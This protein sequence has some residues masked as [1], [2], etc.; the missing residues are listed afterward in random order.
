MLVEVGKRLSA[1][2]RPA[3]TVSRFGGDEFTI[4]CEN[5]DQRAA[6][7]VAERILDALAAPVVIDRNELFANASIGIAVRADPR[8]KAEEMLRDADAAMYRAKEQ[9]RSRFALFDGDLRLQATERLAIE[10]D[11]RRALERD[12]L[13][14]LYQPDIE[15]ASGRVHGVEALVRWR[16][17]QRGLLS[18]H[19][20][21]PIAE[22]SGLIVGLG[23]WVVTEACR[24]LR[25]WRDEGYSLCVSVN[26]SPRQL[27]DPNLPD[28][29]GAAL[30]ASGADPA[31]L[32]LEITESAAVEASSLTLGALRDLGVRLAL[33]DFGAGFSS[34]HQI[35]R[36][37]AVD[38][39][40]IDR[41]FVEELD[42]RP[43]DAA[44]LAAIVGMARAMGMVTVAE[45]IQNE[46]QVRA[47]RE[48]GCDRGQGY[49]FGRPLGAPAIGKLVKAAALGEL[50][51]S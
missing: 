13:L 41:S 27:V 23:E 7:V 19:Q 21:I 25:A 43:A 49:F 5:T 17:P 1:V 30:D 46:A 40:K 3:D 35:R 48:L 47:L 16:H 15:L 36:L 20:F 8:A 32:C 6:S 24:Q 26:I 11:L 4:L 45:G 51:G 31:A 44:I 50:V 39:L 42:R 18:P 37:P 29:V 2:V 10:H 14:L 34:L 33:D 28:V 38:A 22:E 9:G 12:E